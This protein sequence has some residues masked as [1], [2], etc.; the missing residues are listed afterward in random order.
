[1]TNGH[2]SQEDLTLHAFQALSPA[3]DAAVRAHLAGCEACRAEL[4]SVAGDLALV[5]LGVEEAPLPAGA[6]QRFLDRISVDAAAL[7]RPAP[8]PI[9]WQAGNPRT[10]WIPWLA[11][12]ALLL[13]CVTLGV[14]V[15]RLEQQLRGELELT[16]RLKAR[17]AQAQEVLD[18]LSAP[19]AQR[20]L[21]TAAKTPPAPSGRAVY[22]AARGAL[23]FQASNLA[24]LDADQTYELWVIPANGGAP[25]PAGLFRPDQRGDASLVLPPLPLGV[26]AKAFGVTVEKAAG[27]ATPT[28]PILLSGAAPAPGE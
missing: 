27:S 23:I 3:E 22:L 21:L 25:L 7:P 14:E 20:V 13:L 12:A 19:T 26:P 1:M 10:F 11:V 18:T 6:K 28:A 17:S 4:A 24:R 5:A 9:D 16:A 8:V 15:S 2:I